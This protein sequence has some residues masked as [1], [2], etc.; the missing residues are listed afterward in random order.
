MGPEDELI[1]GMDSAVA[2]DWQPAIA[3]WHGLL[4]APRLRVVTR[5]APRQCANPKIAWLQELAPLA[6]REVWLWSDADVIA[7]AG[8]LDEIGTGLAAG[9]LDAMTAAYKVEQVRH[10]HDVLD[11]M[12]VNVELLPGVLLLGRLGR[13]EF[14]YG[15]ATAFRAE[16]F[17]ARVDWRDL[18]AALADDYEL[19]GLLQPVRLSDTLV[20]TFPHASGWVGALQHYFRWQKTVRWC[21]PGGY[22]ALLLVLPLLGWLV[23]AIL[24]RAH[25]GYIW[26][27]LIVLAA[28]TLGGALACRMVGCRLPPAA[29]PGLVLW[30]VIRVLAW[31]LVWLPIPVVWSG[32][33]Q[34]WH[35][36]RRE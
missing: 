22:A 21:R 29:W 23:A 26:G 12:F 19:G 32:R 4:A 20:V 11:A 28:E 31:T 3:A 1:V 14:A 5:D 24:S 16:T 27:F 25:S 13:G 17:R 2:D 35:A 6:Q 36:P 34:T 8:F 7:P 9:E 30:P 15:A 10:G 33:Q 18:G